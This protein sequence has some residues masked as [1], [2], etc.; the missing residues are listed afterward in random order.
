MS[1]KRSLEDKIFDKIVLI[2]VYQYGICWVRFTMGMFETLNPPS[3]L[4]F[5][6]F[7]HPKF[8]SLCSLAIPHFP[9]TLAYT[10]LTKIRFYLKI[11]E[12]I[13]C[14]FSKFQSIS[15]IKETGYDF[16]SKIEIHV[17]TFPCRGMDGLKDRQI[18]SFKLCDEALKN[19]FKQLFLK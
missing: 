18:E 3:Y 13:F 19:N 1:L 7:R 2:Y 9:Y 12:Y 6:S 11:I 15:E 14:D 5:Q 8:S 17:D 16:L 4:K 10:N